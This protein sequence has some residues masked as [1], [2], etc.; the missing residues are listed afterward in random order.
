MTEKLVVEAFWIVTKTAV[1]PCVV[2]QLG[3]TESHLKSRE[4]NHS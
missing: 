2:S 4:I 1:Y 3:Q